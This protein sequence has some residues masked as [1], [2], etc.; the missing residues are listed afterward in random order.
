M[1]TK[2]LPNGGI[3]IYEANFGYYSKMGGYTTLICD[4]PKF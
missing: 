3:Y 1:R 4:I 2:L